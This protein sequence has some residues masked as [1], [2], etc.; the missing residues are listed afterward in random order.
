MNKKDQ[1]KEHLFQLIMTTAKERNMSQKDLSKVLKTSPPRVS[2][3]FS[4]RK[5]LF[6]VDVLIDFVTDLGYD[7]NINIT[8]KDTVS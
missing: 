8:E 6:S 3:L 1:L 5:D 7:I 4:K 2:N